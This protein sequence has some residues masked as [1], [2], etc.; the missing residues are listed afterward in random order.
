MRAMNR[1][2]TLI[3][4]ISLHDFCIIEYEFWA[5]RYFY[6]PSKRTVL[7]AQKVFDK[8]EARWDKMIEKELGK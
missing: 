6:K 1:E 3:E 2:T 4:W 7:Q 8:L 5:K